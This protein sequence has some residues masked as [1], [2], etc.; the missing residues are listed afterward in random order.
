VDYG[1]SGLDV[2]SLD[3]LPSIKDMDMF[4]VFEKR[5]KDAKLKLEREERKKKLGL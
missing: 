5:D 4:G 3:D 2:F 1:E